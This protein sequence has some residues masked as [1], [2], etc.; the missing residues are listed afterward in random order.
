V[1][2]GVRPDGKA[3]AIKA[4]QAKGQQVAMIGDGINDAPALAQADVGIAMGGGSDV[5]IETAAITLMRPSLHG[6]ADALAM[7]QATLRNMKQN[8]LGAFI[9]NVIGIPIAAGVLYPLTGT[10]LSPVIAGAA[11]ALSSITV[12]AN[13]NRL[14]R[15]TPKKQ[16]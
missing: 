14:L 7:S 10:L 9:Y 1:I 6:V 8:L 13:A 15:F 5:A 4:L 11:M 12:V 2:A 3:D 16:A